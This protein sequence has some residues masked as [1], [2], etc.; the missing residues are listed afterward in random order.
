MNFTS[1]HF[2]SDIG[3]YLG[4]PLVKGRVIKAVFYPILDRI[5]SKLVAWKRNMQNKVGRVCLAKYVL[6]SLLAYMMQNL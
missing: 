1:I 4:I 2:T 3:K 6:A 5:G